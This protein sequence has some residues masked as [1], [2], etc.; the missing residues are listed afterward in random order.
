M[1]ELNFLVGSFNFLNELNQQVEITYLSRLDVPV[2]AVTEFF[3]HSKYYVRYKNSN[4]PERKG[5]RV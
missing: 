3:L 5:F 4:I 1:T 2:M